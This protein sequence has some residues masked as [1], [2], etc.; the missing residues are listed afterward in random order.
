[1]AQISPEDRIS[2]EKPL[3]YERLDALRCAPSSSRWK[4]QIKP[5]AQE[6]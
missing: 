1:M 3:L 6:Q 5:P 2:P 4:S